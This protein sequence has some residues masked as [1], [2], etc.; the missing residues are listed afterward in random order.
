MT[1]FNL[2]GTFEITLWNY[3]NL[4][5][6]PTTKKNVDPF[7]TVKSE[8]LQKILNLQVQPSK[9]IW[10]GL[11]E[12]DRLWYVGEADSD[13]VSFS[14]YYSIHTALSSGVYRNK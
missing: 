6:F 10:P 7:T 14:A 3:Y 9:R 4:A 5:Y 8:G 2:K 13:T 1:Y 11:T 12:C